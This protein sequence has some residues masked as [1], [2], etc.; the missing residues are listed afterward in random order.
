MA[1]N[2]FL[3]AL[4]ELDYDS[5]PGNA[6][7]PVQ[8]MSWMWQYCSEYVPPSLVPILSMLKF[9]IIDMVCV[10]IRRR[11]KISLRHVGFY[12]RGDPNNPLSIET[13]FLSLELIQTQ[14]NEA[15]P[16]GLPSSPQVQNVNKYGGWDMRP[17]NVLF[18][19]GEC[20][21]KPSIPSYIYKT[22]QP[23]S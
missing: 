13:S 12:Q 6:D 2:A 4:A 3:V 20:E 8:D 10:T 5:I 14:C 7:D 18:T 15:F 11:I 19:N 23:H 22:G 21:S 9:P 16:E 1:F 17:S